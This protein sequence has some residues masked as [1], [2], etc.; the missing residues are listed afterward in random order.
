MKKIKW[1]GDKLLGVSA[2]IVSLATL[3]ALVYQARIMREHEMKSAFPKLEL[4][5]NNSSEK[6][7]LVLIN[8]GLGPA[9]IEDY[10]MTYEDSVYQMDQ[11]EFA[12]HYSDSLTKAAI[13]SSSMRKGRIIQPGSEISLLR[14]RL[15]STRYHPLMEV[16]QG[17]AELSLRYSSVYHQLWEINGVADIP[18]LI[19]DNPEVIDQMMGD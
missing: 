17:G 19:T 13:G 3:F 2:L 4:W 11:Q 5:N 1:S 9:I 10:F 8:T 6:F 16:F 7:E 15:D 12:H 18:E 14:L